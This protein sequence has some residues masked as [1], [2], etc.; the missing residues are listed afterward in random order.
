ELRLARIRGF[1]YATQPHMRRTLTLGA[2]ALLPVSAGPASEGVAPALESELHPPAI[3]AYQITQYL[4]LRTPTL[5]KPSPRSDWADEAHDFAAHLDL[6]G[7]N[8]IG[9]FYLAMQRGL[10]VLAHR[11]QVGASRLGVTRLSGGGWQSVVLG[12]LDERVAVAVEVAG[13]GS[14][15]TTLTH[16]TETDE[17][18]EN[19][20]DLART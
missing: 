11:S 13:I 10:D 9:F 3:T 12:A 8:G 6:V 4:A 5:P 18:E 14:L 16:P 19:A 15:D 20:T 7:A 2:L 17:I 1:G